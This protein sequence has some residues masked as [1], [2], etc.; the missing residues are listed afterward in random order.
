[1][2]AASED[3]AV[4]S[5]VS[6]TTKAINYRQAGG[7][8]KIPFQGT[9]LMPGASGEAKV[10]NK[11]NHVQIDA[12]F[13]GMQD[14]TKFGLEYLTYVLWAISPQGRAVNVGEIA[15]KSGVGTVKGVTDMQ[16]FGMIVTAEPYYAVTQ[17][18]DEVV[19]ENVLTKALA[20]HVEDI[21]ARYELLGRGSYAS[22]NTNIE[23][24]VFGVHRSAPLELF[25]A[26]NAVRIAR[27][28]QADKY[29]ASSMSKADSQLKTAEDMYR[30]KKDK[31]RLIAA[32]RN[33]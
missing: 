21:S 31:K 32:A 9:D 29:A 5:T 11:A 1:A 4:R 2:S 17:P 23:D 7:S 24:A 16:T 19:L 18:G 3:S 30:D 25:Q 15:V 8:N 28:A 26:R 12:R 6:R 20:T 33:V 10:E 22:P 13:D 27:N 14:S